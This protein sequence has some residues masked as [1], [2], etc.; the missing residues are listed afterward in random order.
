MA[1]ELI[2]C[3]SC[4]HALRLPRDLFGQTVECPQCGNRFAAPAPSAPS[5]VRAAGEPSPVYGGESDFAALRARQSARAPAVALLI[6]SILGMGVG[7]LGLLFAGQIHANPNGFDADIHK[8]LDDNPDLQPD[9]RITLKEVLTAENVAS[10]T[11]TCCGIGLVG[12][13]AVML[14]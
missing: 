10:Y 5:A 8:A 9:Q 2:R 4:D 7:V 14:G 3:P 1:D 12:N 11:A 6:T 13:L